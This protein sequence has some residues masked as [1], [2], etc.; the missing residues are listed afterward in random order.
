ME[1]QILDPACGG[2]MFYFDKH[3]QR[4]LFCDR[5]TFSGKLCDG[6]TFTVEPDEVIDFRNMPFKDES[7]QLVIFDPPHLRRVG[8][9]SWM[10]AKYGQLP[11]DGWEQYIKEG[12]DECWR[13]LAPGGTLVFKWNEQQIK[14]GMIKD[15]FPVNPVMG[16]RT[17]TDTIFIV[18]FKEMKGGK[19]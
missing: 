11:T 5:R 12:F 16:T 15:C 1:K 14:I 7:F 4:V 8:D 13:V 19:Q 17:K 10:K 9:K 2:R 18:F 3:D 6:R